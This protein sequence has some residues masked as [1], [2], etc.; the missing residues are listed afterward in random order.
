MRAPARR[1][2]IALLLALQM[3]RP[4]SPIALQQA[5]PTAIQQHRL[6]GAPGLRSGAAFRSE[7]L[8]LPLP[9]LRLRGGGRILRLLYRTYCRSAS[10]LPAPAVDVLLDMRVRE[11]DLPVDVRDAVMRGAATAEQLGLFLRLE[12]AGWGG[13]IARWLS[14]LTPAL[15]D[16]ILAD[17][18][19]VLVL[20]S[21]VL[22]GVGTK[23]AAQLFLFGMRFVWN[24]DLIVL[25]LALEMIGDVFTACLYAPAVPMS[26]SSAWMTHVPLFEKEGLSHLLLGSS[27]IPIPTS[28]FEIGEYSLQQR[29][30][31]LFVRGA[32]LCVVSLAVCWLGELCRRVVVFLRQCAALLARAFSGSR[33][34]GGSGRAFLERS[35]RDRGN[36]SEA[37][38]FSI[39]MGTSTN[40]RLHLVRALEARVLPR[41][42][43]SCGDRWGRWEDC[44]LVGLRF[45]NCWMGGVSWLAYKHLLASIFSSAPPAGGG[46]WEHFQGGRVLGGQ[47]TTSKAFRGP[48]AGARVYSTG[49]G[50][51]LGRGGLGRGAPPCAFRPPAPA[52]VDERERESRRRAWAESERDLARE[53]EGVR[54]REM[55]R[56]LE[57]DRE[58]ERSSSWAPPQGW[59]SEREDS[60]PSWS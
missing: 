48:Y 44:L 35:V 18:R 42:R 43:R 51:V 17:Q 24:L 41:V 34:W 9:P 19:F 38:T 14:N 22:V 11:G 1:I 39:F 50:R 53:R 27:R 40:F 59:E 60:H 56:A 49:R 33:T 8:P 29:A 7:L 10:H 21:E 26:R 47:G 16:R 2:W 37:L 31:S 23:L 55:E 25:A 4:A 20:L 58:R 36:F 6:R 30:A 32:Q 3:A 13:S 28:F 54:E 45:L 5:A 12:R 46:G 15:R 52:A 57:A